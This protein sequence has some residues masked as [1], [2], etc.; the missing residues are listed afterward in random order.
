MRK[1]FN[2][3]IE[4]VDPQKDSAL[5]LSGGTDSATVL[6]SMLDT[7][8]KPKCYTFHMSGITSVDLLSARN[9]CKDFG[10]ELVE[11]SVP[12]TVDEMYE[13]IKKVLP[14]CE[15]VKKTI[16]QCMIPWMYIYPA[17]SERKIITGIGGD[18]LY[19]TQRKLQVL[20]HNGGDSSVDQYR[21][22]YS[23][24]L[25]FSAAN[26]ARLASYYGK[27][28]VDFYNS[29]EIFSWMKQFSLGAINRPY[30]KYPSVIA[31]MDYYNL[32]NYYRDQTEHS[33]QINSKLRDCHDMLLRSKYNKN[34]N[35]A[36][37]GIYNQI[38]K[39]IGYA[40]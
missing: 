1:I 17:M 14:H 2:R 3:R 7:G 18:D 12:S 30:M 39:E 21:K 6:F 11:I 9:L 15:Y 34:G 24:D 19:C 27:E 37:I 25:K 10:L 23:D 40:R 38:A 36:I 29:K 5:A 4:E 28:N 31:Y 8:R 33:Y 13:D 22:C 16:V 20:Y 32:G 26:I 35:K